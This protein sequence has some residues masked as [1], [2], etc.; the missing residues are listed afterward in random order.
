M[1]RVFPMAALALVAACAPLESERGHFGVDGVASSDGTTVFLYSYQDVP[2]PGGGSV[3]LATTTV[4]SGV[5]ICPNV[6]LTVAHVALDGNFAVSRQP[7]PIERWVD[8]VATD[9]AT[10][11]SWTTRYPV[12]IAEDARVV[13]A[14][15]VREVHVRYRVGGSENRIDDGL[16]MVVLDRSF[17]PDLPY[18]RLSGRVWEPGQIAALHGYGLAKTLEDAGTRRTAQLRLLSYLG[19]DL[20]H[21]GQLMLF[22][23][24]LLAREGDSGGPLFGP[25]P[26]REL[27]GILQGA[28]AVEA[29]A[30]P[31]AYLVDWVQQQRDAL[32]VTRADAAPAVPELAAPLDEASGDLLMAGDTLPPVNDATD[33][34]ICDPD[35]ATACAA[36]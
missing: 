26:D 25:Q 29:S 19:L 27:S 11:Q 13:G 2:A 4:G 6:V 18:P 7:Q 20:K 15:Q 23:S 1:L 24:P 28:S 32:C 22:D 5:L 8:T 3:R 30:I 17:P 14:P 35:C 10:G 36:P 34:C 12:V 16:A 21:D 33:L 9:R 31:V